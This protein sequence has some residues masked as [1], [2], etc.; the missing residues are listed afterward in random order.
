MIQPRYWMG[1]S[2]GSAGKESPCNV[3]DLGSI[4]GW[5]RSPGEGIHYLLQRWPG[6]FQGVAKSYWIIFSFYSSL[7]TGILKWYLMTGEK[8]ESLNT[9][10]GFSAISTLLLHHYFLR[11]SVSPP[12]DVS[13][14]CP[15]HCSITMKSENV[16]CSVVSDC[17]PVDCTPPGSSVH[18]ILQARMLE[19][20]AMPS[21]RGSSQ[22]RERT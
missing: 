3:G 1:L 2:G 9:W 22:P 11:A 13:L 10:K 5:G 16:S 7:C 15:L 17:D 14:S 6:E 12:L 8:L 19:W 18:G 21:S 20:V 4:P